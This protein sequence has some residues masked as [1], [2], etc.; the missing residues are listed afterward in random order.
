[1]FP[2]KWRIH[3]LRVVSLLL[4]VSM[5]VSKHRLLGALEHGHTLWD[6]HEDEGA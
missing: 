1:M 5:S 4:V 3:E 2:R 6:L